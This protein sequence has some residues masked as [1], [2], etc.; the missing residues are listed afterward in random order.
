VTESD[1]NQ[2]WHGNN[3]KS[4]LDLLVDCLK[5]YSLLVEWVVGNPSKSKYMLS[6]PIIDIYAV[7]LLKPAEL[8]EY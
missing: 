2:L 8:R 6:A 5:T 3:S 7:F 1:L 4:G